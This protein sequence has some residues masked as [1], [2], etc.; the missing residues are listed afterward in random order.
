AHAALTALDGV[1]ID[2]KAELGADP[3]RLQLLE[4]IRGSIERQLLLAR[5]FARIRRVMPPALGDSEFGR[6]V[7]SCASIQASRVDRLAQLA[8]DPET[9]VDL[10]AGEG[11][12]M[13]ATVERAERSLPQADTN[14]VAAT[15]A[16]LVLLDRELDACHSE[17]LHRRHV[18][19]EIRRFAIG[20]T[21]SPVG[22]AATS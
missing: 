18:L 14:L 5:S 12:A 8:R 9:T 10:P 1:I 17:L 13:L 7:A 6:Q 15:M 11:D 2:A 21:D 16:M 22:V 3:E 19:E 20:G 4:S